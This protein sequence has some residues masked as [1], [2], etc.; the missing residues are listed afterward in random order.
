MRV[1][2]VTSRRPWPAH[3]GDRLRASL[4]LEAL[5]GHRV[6]LVTPAARG[7]ERGEDTGAAAGAGNGNGDDSLGAEARA[8]SGNP[9]AAAGPAGRSGAVGDAAPPGAAVVRVVEVRRPLPVLAAAAVA[10]AGRRLPLHTLLAA[11]DWRRAIARAAE[12]D[13]PFD[14]AVVLLSRLVPWLPALPARRTI[15]DAIDSAAVGMGERARAARGPARLFWRREAAAAAR[16]EAAAARRFDA[17]VA[18]TAEESARFGPRGVTLPVGIAL[19]PAAPPAGRT[20]DFAFWGRLPYFAN[21]RAADLLLDRLWP[22][23]RARRPGATLVLGGAEAPR[24]L[25]ARDGRDGVTVVSPIGDRDALLARVRVALLPIGHGSGQS[26]KTLEAAAAGCAIAGTRRAFRSCEHL[27][28]AALVE[29][30]LDRLA[31]RAVELVESGCFATAGA[32][33]RALVAAHDA[34]PALLARM[35]RL[36]EEG[37]A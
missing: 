31:D 24:R 9:G 22:R 32:R 3:S 14:V 35:A 4:W 8:G 15:L 6:T 26:L 17:V 36:I 30:D 18:V 1:L 29:D 34:R 23:I 27:A 11:A 16:L 2:L 37:A 13:G 10:A 12:D 19:P 28:A 20:I 5:R 33:L 25:R 7:P 21:R